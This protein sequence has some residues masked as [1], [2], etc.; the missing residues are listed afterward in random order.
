MD[1]GADAS[2][3][4]S[5]PRSGEPSPDGRWVTYDELGRIRGIGRESAVKLVQRKRWRRVR[6]NDGEARVLVPPDWLTPIKAASEEVS[7]NNS[8]HSSPDI[9][10]V[11][12]ALEATIATL[13]VRAER[14]EAEAD[15]TIA[16]LKDARER[17]DRE[18]LRAD[19]TEQRADDLRGKLDAAGSDLAAARTQGEQQGREVDR[20]RAAL[21]EAESPWWRRLR[22][23]FFPSGPGS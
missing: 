13:T 4:S 19:Q 15:R 10:R 1:Q 7:P 23:S 21:V 20:L 5:G 16:A 11:M 6:G 14:A 8:P 2:G 22:R 18:Q 12:A 17:G 9:P 3:E